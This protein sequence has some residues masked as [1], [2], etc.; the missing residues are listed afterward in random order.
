MVT[1]MDNL[2]ASP[3]L[4]HELRQRG[5]AATGTARQNRIDRKQMASL[6]TEDSRRHTVPWGTIYTKKHKDAEVV[7]F[8][9]K[10]NAFVLLLSTGFNGWEPS[11]E[12]RRQ[13]TKSSTSAKTARVPFEGESTKNLMIPCIIDSYNH[14][15]NGVDI[16][17]QLRAGFQSKRRIKRGGQQALLFFFLFELSITNS[18]LL[19]RYRGRNQQVSHGA[20]R[21]LLFEQIIVKYGQFVALQKQASQPGL[22]RLASL[23][24]TSHSIIQL[25]KRQF[26]A[27]CSSKKRNVLIFEPQLAKALP[28]KARIN[29]GCQ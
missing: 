19:Y 29:T 22:A 25:Q 1:I 8:G 16:G 7:Q 20:F 14:H 23:T 6:R 9:F 5:I 24:T 11:I 4:F 12:L 28:Q 15:M 17:D 13:P 18:Y 10:D 21:K 3:Q 26:C 2:F 27:Y